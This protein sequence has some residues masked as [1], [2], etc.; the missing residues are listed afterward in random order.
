[1]NS[2]ATRLWPIHSHRSHRFRNYHKFHETLDD[3][4]SAKQ[5]ILSVKHFDWYWSIR[6]TKNQINTDCYC[7]D[8]EWD[9]F[10]LDWDWSSRRRICD[11]SS[12][13]FRSANCTLNIT[14]DWSIVIC[15]C[16]K[17][18][19]NHAFANRCM[20]VCVNINSEKKNASIFYVYFFFLSIW[21]IADKISSFNAI[22]LSTLTNAILGHILMSYARWAQW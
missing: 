17:S 6:W 12:D 18:V 19:T 5:N 10:T 16:Y 11:M 2:A 20:L 22:S 1:M 15:H 21:R 8:G 9:L 7:I 14:M 4:K 3:Y 13:S